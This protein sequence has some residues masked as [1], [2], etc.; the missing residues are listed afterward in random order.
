MVYF[1]ASRSK[2]TRHAAFTWARVGLY[3][4]GFTACPQENIC[5]L[6]IYWNIKPAVREHFAVAGNRVHNVPDADAEHC[7]LEVDERAEN[8]Y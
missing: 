5:I 4:H 1:H 6:V 7:E 3:D 2:I 8:V